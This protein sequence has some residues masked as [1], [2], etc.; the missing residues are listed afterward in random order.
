MTPTTKPKRKYTRWTIDSYSDHVWH[1]FNRTVYVIPGQTWK[2]NY[3]KLWHYCIKHGAYET[4]PHDV[5]REDQ[6]SQC[7]GC[8]AEKSKA[9]KDAIT[10]E[11]LGQTTPDGHK[12]LEHVGY[13]Q[14][15]RD[16]KIGRIGRAIY[17]YQCVVCGNTEATALGDSLKRLGNTTHCG[18]LGKKDSAQ[19][20]QRSQ[21]QHDRSCHLYVYDTIADT[22]LKI[23]IAS[24]LSKR[25]TRSYGCQLYTIQLKRAEAWG[26]EQVIHYIMRRM[27]NSYDLTDVPAWKN[28]KGMEAGSTEVFYSVSMTW[29]ID[30]IQTLSQ[31]VQVCGFDELIDRYIPIEDQTHRQLFRWDGNRLHQSSGHGFIGFNFK[32]SFQSLFNSLVEN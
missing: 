30:L 3:T 25:E 31:E 5:L 32:Q 18:C 28:E 20:F 13:K 8:K 12:I 16:I 27:G 19:T 22:G 2:N 11:F 1:M 15:P 17:R 24:N 14:I 9:R 4:R 26:V 7:R 21:S 6:G 10:A 29:L 23:G